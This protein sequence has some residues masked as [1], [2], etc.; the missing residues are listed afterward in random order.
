MVVVSIIGNGLANYTIVLDSNEL[1][2]IVAWA[3]DGAIND[4]NRIAME[5]DNGYAEDEKELESMVEKLKVING[6][7]EANNNF[8]DI[9]KV[10]E[11]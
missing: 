10:V 9:K 1:E 2:L 5:P 11:L 7:L 6:L 3:L 8:R 4:R